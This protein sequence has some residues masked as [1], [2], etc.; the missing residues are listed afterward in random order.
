MRHIEGGDAEGLL[1]LADLAAHLDPELGVQVRER[2]VQQQH[3]GLDHQRAGDRDALQLTA[4]ELMRPT[5]AIPLEAH[6]HQ[7]T[8]DAL[9]DY[10]ARDTPRLEP[11]GDVASDAEVREHRVILKYHAGVAP[12]RR[13][14]VDA[15]LAEADRA[16]VEIGE[17]RDHPQERGLA[18]ARRTQQREELAVPDRER[19]SRHC[20]HRSEPLRDALDG[21]RGHVALT[22]PLLRNGPL[23]LPRGERVTRSLLPLPLRERVGVRG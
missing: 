14:P 10:L 21:Y 3:L 2:L 4:R 18:A 22:L 16:C 20:G 1:E 15:P 8:G 5:L 11:I 23:P 12:M 9:V 19:H 7:R 17:A 13:Q 6:Q